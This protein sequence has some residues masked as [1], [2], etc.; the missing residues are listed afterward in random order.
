MGFESCNETRV[1]CDVDGTEE[2]SIK[3]ED[4]LDTMGEVGIKVEDALDTMEEVGIKVEESLD[5]MEEISIK[6]EEAI[7][8]NDENPQAV[9]FPPTV[10]EEEVRLWGMCEVVAAYACG[11]FTAPKRKLWNYTLIMSCCVLCFGFHIVL[12]FRLQS[13]SE[14]IAFNGR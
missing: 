2:F 6:G 7:D 12:K 5:I 3:F 14:V 4:A 9:M 1:K 8:I 10:T 11:S 13:F